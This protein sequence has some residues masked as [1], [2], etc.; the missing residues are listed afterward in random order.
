M[1]HPS[2]VRDQIRR[3]GTLHPNSRARQRQGA[4]SAGY[5]N[6]FTERA[7]AGEVARMTEDVGDR[8]LMEDLRQ[9]ADDAARRADG[10]GEQAIVG[11]LDR[12]DGGRAVMLEL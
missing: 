6:V 8:D 1:H 11:G 3:H 4:D 10:P 2:T 12:R 9:R 7:S 5:E